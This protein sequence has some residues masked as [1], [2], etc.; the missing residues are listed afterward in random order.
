MRNPDKR[1]RIDR[2]TAIFTPLRVCFIG[3]M[4]RDVLRSPL[5][6]EMI[7]LF[8]RACEKVRGICYRMDN[9]YERMNHK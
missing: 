6:D 7:K 8:D 4:P 2:Q 5:G 3:E 9:D 1:A